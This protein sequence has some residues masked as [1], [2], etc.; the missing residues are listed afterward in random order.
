VITHVIRE[1]AVDDEYLLAR[2]RDGDCSAF[3]AL[4]DTYYASVYSVLYRMVGDQ[5][6]DLAQEVFWRLYTNPPTQPDSHVAAWLYRVA[7]NLGYNALRSAK[8]RA[9]Y[10]VLWQRTQGLLRDAAATNPEEAILRRDEADTVRCALARL[11]RR[12]AQIL[13]LRHEGLSYRE[14]AECVGIAPSSVGTLLARAEQAFYRAYE[15]IANGEKGDH[16]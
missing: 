3:D 12:D 5:A 13:V 14:V 4:F 6:D 16:P 10:E 7:L 1:R 11:K 8:R 15:S 2:L 9:A